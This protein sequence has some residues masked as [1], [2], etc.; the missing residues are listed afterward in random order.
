MEEQS[1]LV[2]LEL[3]T[4]AIQSDAFLSSGV[5]TVE[6][7]AAA[8]ATC[9]TGVNPAAAVA[10]ARRNDRRSRFRTGMVS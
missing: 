9:E 3:S 10:P 6:A 2:G 5:V 1:V 7:T 8:V 4:P